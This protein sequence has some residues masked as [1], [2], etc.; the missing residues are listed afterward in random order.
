MGWGRGWLSL[1]LTL[2]GAAQENL[3]CVFERYTL[4]QHLEAI[5]FT[6]HGMDGNIDFAGWLCGGSNGLVAYLSNRRDRSG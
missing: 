5:H 2:R 6:E 3:V 1:A 4:N